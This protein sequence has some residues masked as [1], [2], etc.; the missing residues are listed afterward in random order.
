MSHFRLP[1]RAKRGYI[2]TK[3]YDKAG[4]V[5]PARIHEVSGLAGAISGK[6]MEVMMRDIADDHRASYDNIVIETYE[7]DDA[8]CQS[9]PARGD[10]FARFTHTVNT[11]RYRD[12]YDR[13][14]GTRSER[15]SD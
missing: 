7:G 10:H 11:N 5:V 3:R 13:I 14:F 1:V 4:R 2:K 12:G 15:D 6:E 9:N 8:P